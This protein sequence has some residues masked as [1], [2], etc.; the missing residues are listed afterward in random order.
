MADRFTFSSTSNITAELV[1]TGLAVAR[2]AVALGGGIST[3][4]LVDV[5]NASVV[6]VGGKASANSLA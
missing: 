4:G 3:S 6:L 1:T 2:Q 5:D